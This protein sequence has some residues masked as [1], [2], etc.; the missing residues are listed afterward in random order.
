F[1]TPTGLN[2]GSDA[3]RKPGENKEIPGF[4]AIFEFPLWRRALFRALTAKG[5]IRYFLKRTYGGPDVD[6]AMVE[7]DY[8][9][10]RQ[11]GAA[12]APFAFLS[13][14]LFSRDVRLLYEK[15]NVP[16][17]VPHGTRGDFRD[18]SGA[19]WTEERENWRVQPFESGALVHY[20]QPE[21]FFSSFEEFL[22]GA[23]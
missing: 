7:Y 19:R 8:L 13:G 12:N 5:S 2:R 20:E 18:F 23:R 11:P 17:W 15:L 6:E 21:K 3:L 4:S 10:T 22:A 1:V 14:R 9:S 16:V